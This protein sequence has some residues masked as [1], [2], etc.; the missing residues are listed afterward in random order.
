M[1]RIVAVAAIAA[2][3][4]MHALAQDMRWPVRVTEVV[5]TNQGRGGRGG[6]GGGM[7]NPAPEETK[8]KMATVLVKISKSV[9]DGDAFIMLKHQPPTRGKTGGETTQASIPFAD[10]EKLMDALKEAI[11]DLKK[12]TSANT[13]ESKEA[14]ANGD[15]SFRAVTIRDGHKKHMEVTFRASG[16]PTVFEVPQQQ[17][18]LFLNLLKNM[19]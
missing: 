11:A 6:R 9:V 18:E 13:S 17:V 5:Q 8:E 1:K 12:P 10:R 14:Y 15:K 2:L 16:D 3:T 7:Q 4:C 19:K